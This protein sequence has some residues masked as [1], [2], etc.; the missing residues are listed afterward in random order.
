[1]AVIAILLILAQSKVAVD[2]VVRQAARLQEVLTLATVVVT[3][4]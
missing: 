2:L 4:K 1:M 3:V